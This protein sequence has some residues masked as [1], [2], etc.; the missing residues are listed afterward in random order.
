MG[1]T[2]L[3]TGGSGYVAGWCIVELLKRGYTVRATLRSLSREPA[4]RAAIATAAGDTGRLTFFAADLTA[5]AGWDEAVAGCDYVL[6]VASPMGGGGESLEALVAPAR[7]GTTRV[8]AAA[9]R[10]GVRRVVM[11]SSCAAATPR[12]QGGDSVS[13]ETA[14]TD[15]ED[16]NLNAYRK[17]KAISE[18]HAWDWMAARSDP[19]RLTT[20]LPA[21]IF[22][23]VLTRENLGS[24][25]LIDGLL[26]GRPPGIPRISFNIVDVRDLADLH[27]RAMTAPEAAGQRF[28][29]SGQFLW[30]KEVAAILRDN[31]GA[32]AARVPTGGMPDVLVRLLAIFVKPLRAITPIIGRRH[33]FSSARARAVLGFDPRPASATIIDCGRSLTD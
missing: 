15:L 11:T 24:V 4:V 31:L 12:D 30:M 7:D 10:A 2:V 29:A 16:P 23:P 20:I 22:G 27:I 18:R 25:G 19:A 3:V 5:D 1:E 9:T 32:A 17:S 14:W 13:D 8:L 26:K 33:S 21:A 28:I 6:H